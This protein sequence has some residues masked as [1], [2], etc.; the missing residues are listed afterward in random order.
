MF[1]NT[2]VAVWETGATWENKVGLKR[3]DKKF[4]FEYFGIKVPMRPPRSDGC[5]IYETFERDLGCL[6][7]F[8]MGSEIVIDATDIN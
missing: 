7:I 5:Y 4:R 6:W 1:P 2:C 8:I 3:E